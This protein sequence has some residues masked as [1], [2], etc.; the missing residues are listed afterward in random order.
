[1]RIVWL[2]RGTWD[3]GNGLK[4]DVFL[5]GDEGMCCMGFAAI[6]LGATET[7][8]WEAETWK[9]CG[10]SKLAEREDAADLAGHGYE[11]LYQLNDVAGLKDEDRVRLLN[12]ELKQLGLGFRFELD[13]PE[14][15]Q[16]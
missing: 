3:R 10:S 7:D 1:M 15:V 9:N 5:L 2:K 16:A 13:G 12:I 8:I 11:L 4:H 6:E 14:E